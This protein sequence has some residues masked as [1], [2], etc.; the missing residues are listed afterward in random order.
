MRLIDKDKLMEKLE[1]AED[2]D[3]C[4]HNHHS[5]Y[6]GMGSEFV[7][8]CEAICEAP[9]VDIPHWIPCSERMP[10][11]YGNYL[12]TTYDGDVDITIKCMKCG[13]ELS[14]SS[15]CCHYP[16]TSITWRYDINEKTLPY[17]I[18]NGVNYKNEM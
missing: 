3:N 13:L 17:D 11:E 8:A 16:R 18:W 4:K 10:E 14:H 15:S 7:T 9:E 2:C 5:I 1:I 12:I 6:C